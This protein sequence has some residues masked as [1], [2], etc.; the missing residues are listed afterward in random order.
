MLYKLCCCH[1]NIIL[2]AFQF[3]ISICTVTVGLETSKNIVVYCEADTRRLFLPQAR[4][5]AVGHAAASDSVRRWR[6]FMNKAICS[7]KQDPGATAFN[8]NR[9]YSSYLETQNSALEKAR[10]DM[11]TE[12]A[13]SRSLEN[14]LGVRMGL[15]P[16]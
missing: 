11:E 5:A 15:C 7:T 1:P 3:L 16:R 8:F 10:R 13:R 4:H 9:H 14:H 2:I 6:E 12:L